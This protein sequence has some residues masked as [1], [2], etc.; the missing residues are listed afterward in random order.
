MR[1]APRRLSEGVAP[2]AC[3]AY[4]DLVRVRVHFE[5]TGGLA[6]RRVEVFVDS[7]SLPP[8][9]AKRLQALLAQ[10]RFFDLPLELHSSPEGAD[11]FQYRVTVEADS[12]SHTV[13]AGEA[14]VPQTMWPLLDWL[15]RHG[16]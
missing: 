14:A 1:M 15:T 5:R 3:P 16:A 6:G 9:Q 10:S 12:R 4:N 7:D 2:E 13:E 8:T 11:R